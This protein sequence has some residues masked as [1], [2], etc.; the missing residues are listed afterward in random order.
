MG[1][2]KLDEKSK[3]ELATKKNNLYVDLIKRMDHREI[4][5]GVIQFLDQLR[6][7]RIFVALGSASQNALMILDRIG[8]RE[9]FDVV[10]DGNKVSNAKPDPEVFLKGALELGIDPQF[11]LVFE[12]AQAGIEAARNAGMSVVGVG[13]S[14]IL[15]G[16]D[17]YIPGFQQMTIEKLKSWYRNRNLFPSTI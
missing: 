2:I 17:F 16:A 5:P 9:K 4:L 7:N 3:N 11:C 6:E 10:I 8:I 15:H 12:D 14:E 1:G 13:S